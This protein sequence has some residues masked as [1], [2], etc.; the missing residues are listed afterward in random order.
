MTGGGTRPTRE[1]SRA[2]KGHGPLLRARIVEATTA[3]LVATGDE[4]AVSI[5]SVAEAVGVTPPSIYLH[6]RDKDELIFE[7]SRE[8]IA[9]IAGECIDAHADVEDPVERVRQVSHSFVRRGIEHPEPYRVAFMSP[10]HNVP[11]GFDPSTDGGNDAFTRIVGL[12]HDAF[13]FDPEDPATHVRVLSMFAAIHGIIAL[14]IAKATE[15]VEFPWPEVTALV[16]HTLDIHL[17]A[18]AALGV[19]R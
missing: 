14:M 1:G 13:G 9:Q 7:C 19:G 12:W 2:R 15:P 17:R 5:R 18:A 10:H 16:D 4:G 8:L 3:L 6:F 11:E